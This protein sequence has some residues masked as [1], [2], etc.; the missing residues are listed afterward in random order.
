MLQF[1]LKVHSHRLQRIPLLPHLQSDQPLECL[2]STAGV[3]YLFPTK[4]ASAY[5]VS[6]VEVHLRHFLA[7][8]M[9]QSGTSAMSMSSASHLGVV[10]L[11][12]QLFLTVYQMLCITHLLTLHID[13][14]LHLSTSLL[15]HVQLV[16]GRQLI[17]DRVLH[18][19]LSLSSSG[20]NSKSTC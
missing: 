10:S 14:V 4:V 6:Q 16:F 11:L 20:L 18:E 17:L 13:F 3:I 9:S 12:Q 19:F 8:R 1:V 5:P 2:V 15:L 7:S